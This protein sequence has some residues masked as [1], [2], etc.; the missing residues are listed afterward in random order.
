MAE[1]LGHET[2]RINHIG[3]WGTQFG[4]LIAYLRAEHPN[5]E[6]EPPP[7]SD[8]VEFYRAAKKKFDSDE[9]FKKEA[10]TAVV[11]LQSGDA[12]S[13]RAWKSL[14]DVSIVAMHDLYRRLNVRLEE[15]GESFYNPMLAPVVAT[16]TAAGLTREDD[17]ALIMLPGSLKTVATITPD[18]FHTLALAYLMPPPAE[19]VKSNPEEQNLAAKAYVKAAGGKLL[20]PDLQKLAATVPPVAFCTAAT[21]S[22]AAEDLSTWTVR[23][24]KYKQPL[25]LRKR[26]GG[27]TYDTTDIAAV[28]Y[29]LQKLNV[30]RIIYVTDSRQQPHFQLVFAAA[31]EAG[32]LDR[33]AA[34]GTALPPPELTHVGFGMVTGSD[35]KPIKTRDGATVKLA[36][37]LDEAVNVVLTEST[38]REAAKVALKEGGGAAPTAA[39]TT[40]AA[41]AAVEAPAS[42]AAAAAGEPSAPPAASAADAPAAD[43]GK[44]KGGK[45][46]GGKGGGKSGGGGGGGAAAASDAPR[47]ASIAIDT[48]E[49]FTEAELQDNAVAMGLGAVKYYDLSRNKT[50]DYA[51]SYSAMLDLRGETGIRMQ[52]AYCRLRSIMRKAGGEPL[53]AAVRD[54]DL[55]PSAEHASEVGLCIHLL[56]F[57]HVVEFA[58]RD[59]SPNIV[60]DYLSDLVDKVS[61]FHRDCRVIGVPETQSRSVPPSQ[62]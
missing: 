2:L 1:Y 20:L 47:E 38:R 22:P 56:R 55:L 50:S 60:C 40:A 3:D 27:Y 29:R 44:G 39:A 26:D 18:E 28:Q 51:F 13:L 23:V 30:D 61:A 41:T 16:L 59:C 36:D 62:V 48:N 4:M 52:Y 58:F 9:A 14:C 33:T 25:M 53:V 49:V 35:G 43:G 45:G 12:T 21:D 54:S 57:P 7:L 42:D 32:W 24:P 19:G 15:V 17:G 10:H 5:F 11:A 8:L 31:K 34:D 6:T 46:G 37:L